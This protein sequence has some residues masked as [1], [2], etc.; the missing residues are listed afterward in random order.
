MQIESPAFLGTAQKHLKKVYPKDVCQ[1]VTSLPVIPGTV[2][3]VRGTVEKPLSPL[4]L[5]TVGLLIVL[6]LLCLFMV[7]S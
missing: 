1:S 7:H 3:S 5:E 6:F 4:G 2:G